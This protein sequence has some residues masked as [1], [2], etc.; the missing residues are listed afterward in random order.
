M[1]KTRTLFKRILSILSA[2]S[3]W[4]FLFVPSFVIAEKH[5]SAKTTNEDDS[6][7]FELL[8]GYLGGV[9]ITGD[10]PIFITQAFDIQ[11]TP[12]EEHQQCYYVYEEDKIVGKLS[13]ATV[14]GNQIS[15]FIV[16]DHS[17]VKNFLTEGNEVAFEKTDY[18]EVIHTNG[19]TVL[20]LGKNEG[21]ILGFG[22]N[23]AK[24][25]RVSKKNITDKLNCKID[26]FLSSGFVGDINGSPIEE[27]Y[28]ELKRKSEAFK[29]ISLGYD[30]NTVPFSEGLITRKSNTKVGVA[31]DVLKSAEDGNGYFLN[32]DL[33]GNQTLDGSPVCWAACGASIINYKKGTNLVASDIYYALKNKYNDIPSG[34]SYWENKMWDLYGV[35]MTHKYHKLSYSTV[36]STLSAR[37]PIYCAFAYATPSGS[38]SG[39]GHAVTLIGSYQNA[40]KVYYIYMDPDVVSYL[41]SSYLVIN[42]VPSS[43]LNTTHSYTAYYYGMSYYNNWIWTYY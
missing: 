38:L 35:S 11:N 3:L 28:A 16:G 30:Y 32:V 29:D 34:Q 22:K 33:I 1:K 25:Q 19:R 17:A 15:S 8:G 18:G 41:N 20:S 13:T 27:S 6:Y 4:V 23:K 36:C 5:P 9:G 2:V 10:K 26:S 21:K 42:S 24:L 7:I 37:K 39:A 31:D 40:G 14:D 12:E 43:T